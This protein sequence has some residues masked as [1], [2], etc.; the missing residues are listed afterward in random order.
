M[1]VVYFLD[2]R[3]S[4]KDNH[5]LLFEHFLKKVNVHSVVEKNAVCA[6]KIHVGEDGNTNYVSPLFVRRVCDHVRNAGGRPILTDTTTLYRGRRF[7]G[8]LH[9]ELAHEHGFSFAPF[10]IGDGLYGDDSIDVNGSKIASLFAHVESMICVSHFKGH[11]NCGF[12]GALKN[13][14]MGCAAKGGKLEMHSRSKPSIDQ[15]KCTKCLRCLEYCIFDAVKKTAQGLSID[16]RSCSGCGGCMSICPERAIVFTWDAASSDIQK[17]IARYAT[18]SV[19]SAKVFYLNFLINISP[20]CDCFHTNQPMIADDIGI[21]ASTDPVSIDQ[22]CYDMVKTEID[23]LY[24]RVNAQDQLAF[25][26]EFGLGERTYEI[27][28]VK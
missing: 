23:D 25:A 24:P 19:R 13:L 28:S 7:R 3:K 12:G 18:D 4:Y 26:E 14:G 11:L 5:L 9:I 20:N 17:G 1:S 10:V 6:L 2:L 22:A 8:D 16:H 21:L 15:K 27:K